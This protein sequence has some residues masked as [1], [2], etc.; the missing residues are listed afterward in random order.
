MNIVT[1]CLISWMAA[2]RL[3]GNRRD[4]RLLCLAGVL[5]DADGLGIVVDW[6]QRLAGGVAGDWYARYHHHLLHGLPGALV[7]AVAL[8]LC[9]EHKLRTA[10]G[11]L[12]VVHVHLLSD[13]VGSRGAA[14]DDIW[15]VPWLAPVSEALTLSWTGQWPLDGWQNILLT[16]LLLMLVFYR[17][18]HGGP[19]PVLLFGERAE[20]G[21]VATV[22]SR[23]QRLRRR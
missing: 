19:T 12:V 23:W 10:L 4:L 1:H 16:V 8:G 9:A 3:T 15:P 17:A 7:L 2:D 5:P 11:C 14:P 6:G 21:F 13:L 22:Q 20:R 18:A